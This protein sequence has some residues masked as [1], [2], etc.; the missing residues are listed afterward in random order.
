MPPVDATLVTWIELGAVASNVIA[1]L[2]VPTTTD[3]V[4]D[5]T[6]FH[7]A[8]SATLLITLDDETHTDD[9]PLVEA[10]PA[11]QLASNIP[12]IR[13]TTV[14]LCDPVIA[15]F[16]A[17]MLLNAGPSNVWLDV[18]VPICMPLVNATRRK[19]ATPLAGFSPSAVSVTQVVATLPLPPTS[20]AALYRATPNPNP[21]TVTLT[22][23]VDPPF[24]RTTL[25]GPEPS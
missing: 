25:L 24:N 23:P 5:T 2:S 21:T 13:P 17:W 8:P 22:P 6:R 3:V 9:A 15:V 14:T 4:P 12:P 18:I 19:A 11:P 7:Q 16:T 20:E 1:L 10:N